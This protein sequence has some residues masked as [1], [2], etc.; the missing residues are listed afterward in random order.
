MY[1]HA[2]A[3]KN[4]GLHAQST[5][6]CH[7]HRRN[8]TALSVHHDDI[9]WMIKE[10]G[11]GIKNQA[12]V[13]LHGNYGKWIGFSLFCSYVC[14][15]FICNDLVLCMYVSVVLLNCIEYFP[16]WCDFIWRISLSCLNFY[17]EAYINARICRFYMVLHEMILAKWGKLNQEW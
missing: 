1:I 17:L 7:D 11:E 6:S 2:I 16:M 8:K 4:K 12:N 15:F 3:V 5:R 14:S 9:C 13:L 10:E